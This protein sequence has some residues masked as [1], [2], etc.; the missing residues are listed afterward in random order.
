[1]H[2]PVGSTHGHLV[3]HDPASRSH[4]LHVTW[5]DGAA[6]AS[7]VPMLKFAVVPKAMNNPFFDLTRDACVAEP[8]Q[9]A[10]VERTVKFYGEGE[11]AILD[12]IKVSTHV[13]YNV[14]GT[15]SAFWLDR[16]SALNAVR[17][18]Q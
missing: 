17:R 3:M 10:N 6:R 14:F 11:T 8:S 15:A 1:M 18:A 5:S 9:L 2:A 16:I 7:R 13:G 4:P 12:R